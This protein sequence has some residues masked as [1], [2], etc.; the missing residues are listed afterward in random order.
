MASSANSIC[1]RLKHQPHFF[2][3][4][5]GFLYSLADIKKSNFEQI[6]KSGEPI[7]WATNVT[8]TPLYLLINNQLIEQ[9]E[10][11]FTSHLIKT[12]QGGYVM[13]N[14]ALTQPWDDAL[15]L[16]WT[17]RKLCDITNMDLYEMYENI[18]AKL[19]LYTDTMLELFDSTIAQL[20]AHSEI[21]EE[22][23]KMVNQ[24][25]T[26]KVYILEYYVKKV[27]IIEKLMSTQSKYMNMLIEMIPNMVKDVT[28][29]VKSRV[30]K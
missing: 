22:N 29:I 19:E 12:L 17:N 26:D 21:L 18:N 11:N 23:K 9:K 16:Y 15:V 27:D 4:E 10:D 25:E 7:M 28:K 6:I 3:N 2:Q 24:V 1:T 14:G 5:N 13:R 8:Y 30:S 20:S